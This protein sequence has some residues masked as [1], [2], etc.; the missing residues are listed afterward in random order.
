MQLIEHFYHLNLL[1]QLLLTLHFLSLLH[2]LT[3]ASTGVALEGT[4]EPVDSVV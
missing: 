3:A 4:L 2:F 1:K